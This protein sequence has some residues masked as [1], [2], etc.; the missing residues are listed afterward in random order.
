VAVVDVPDDDILL[1]GWG[2]WEILPAPAPE[3]PV[4]VIVM[5]EDD[6]VMSVRPTH[7]AEASSS[8]AALRTTAHQEQEREYVSAPPAHLSDA[9]V[10]QP[11]WQEFSDHGS[12]LN[13]ALNE[14]LRIHRGPA[15][16]IFLVRIFS[17]GFAV[18]SL[19]FL[20]CLRSPDPRSL[21]LCPPLAR[22]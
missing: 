13:W 6:C 1:P 18:S 2:Q 17:L 22:V 3:L 12:S 19:S 15:W 5:R 21:L 8:R 4:G 14:A 7:G 20:P 11:L 16:R 9:Q 10:E